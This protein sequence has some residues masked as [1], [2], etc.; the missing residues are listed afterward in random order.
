MLG[1]SGEGK[2]KKKKKDKEGGG[3]EQ[4]EV[5]SSALLK[6]ARDLQRELEARAALAKAKDST[7]IEELFEVVEKVRTIGWSIHWS[8]WMFDHWTTLAGE[9][10]AHP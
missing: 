4:K 8:I 7:D 6:L 10:G 5:L 9:R 1:G 3:E 2:K